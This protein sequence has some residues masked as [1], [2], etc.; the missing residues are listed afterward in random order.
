MTPSSPLRPRCAWR[1]GPARAARPAR[2]RRRPRPARRPR[3]RR[4]RAGRYVGSA[5]PSVCLWMSPAGRRRGGVDLSACL[6][7]RCWAP[8]CRVTACGCTAA[9]AEE[10]TAAGPSPSTPPRRRHPPDPRP[11]RILVAWDGRRADAWAR[12]DPRVLRRSTRPARWR[13]ATTWRCSAPGRSG[14]WSSR[15][16]HPAAVGPRAAAHARD[17]DAA[18]HRPARRWR[19]GRQRRTPT[20]AARPGHHPH[21][22]AAQ[23]TTATPSFSLGP[24]TRGGS[25]APST[26][27][28][29]PAATA[30]AAANIESSR[31]C[32]RVRLDMRA[33]CGSCGR[34]WASFGGDSCWYLEYRNGPPLSA[35]APAGQRGAAPGARPLS[36]S[37]PKHSRARAAAAD[38][39]IPA[40][41]RRR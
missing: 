23:A 12:G 22:P 36:F 25:S 37:G 16:P 20:A 40:T 5:R 13:G 1:N 39:S 28:A 3:R 41:C 33:P 15:P 24:L 14:G 21:G 2:C 17:L 38:W 26:R 35:L 30:A 32:R 18:G 4:R 9:T 31:N 10:P 19:R 29:D 7:R 34:R 27:V 6:G 11:V 8:R